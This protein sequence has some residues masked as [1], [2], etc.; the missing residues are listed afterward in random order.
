MICSDNETT[1]FGRSTVIFYQLKNLFVARRIRAVFQFDLICSRETAGFRLVQGDKRD[2]IN[3]VVS[4]VE[5]STYQMI[6]L[7]EIFEQDGRS[8]LPFDK[9]IVLF[10]VDRVEPFRLF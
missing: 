6:F 3:L 5:R 4:E 1:V 2:Q 7:Q 8:V 10:P 9:T